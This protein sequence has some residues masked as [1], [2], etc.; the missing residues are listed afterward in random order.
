MRSHKILNRF[1]YL[2][3]ILLCII[4][5]DF[6]IN[7]MPTYFVI[8]VVAY[9][10]LSLAILTNKIIHKEHKKL[11]FPK[12]ILLSIILVLGYA[13]FYYKLSRDLAHAFKDGM[14]LSAIDSVYF[15]ITT[16]T[17]T[18]YGDIYPIT[19]TAK[20]FVASEMILGYILSTIIMA[21]FVIRFIE[22]D[23]G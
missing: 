16:F 19:N 23:K 4:L 21:A 17:T 18:G 14:I 20:M 2:S 13:N 3:L 12:I 7:F 9:F 1:L 5:I 6:Y 11:V 10:F 15:S 8:V 22:A